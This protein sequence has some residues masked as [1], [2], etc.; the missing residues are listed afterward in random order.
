MEY[1]FQSLRFA[2]Q[3]EASKRNQGVLAHAVQ[4][5]QKAVIYGEREFPQQCGKSKKGGKKGV[6]LENIKF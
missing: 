4:W 6:V 5:R 2:T 3:N 1:L